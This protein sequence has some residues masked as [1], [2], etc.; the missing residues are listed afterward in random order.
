MATK[1][2][3]IARREGVEFKSDGNRRFHD[4]CRW[5][6]CCVRL[7]AGAQGSPQQ[8]CV[9]AA[10]WGWWQCLGGAPSKAVSSSAFLSLGEG[11]D[12]WANC[13]AACSGC[14][15]SRRWGQ[16]H[17]AEEAVERMWPSD[18]R[19]LCRWVCLCSVAKDPSSSAGP[20]YSQTAA[21]SLWEWPVTSDRCVSCWERAQWGSHALGLPPL[22]QD[23]RGDLFP[24]CR[25][26]SG[27]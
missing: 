21:L 15:R 13:A 3:S 19:Q 16:D 18:G 23:V 1:L 26:R 22:S 7:V 12:F 27:K 2:E 11:T 17:R 9:L 14:H 4:S 6:C 20:Q 8:S 10:V 24:K 25:E 5:T